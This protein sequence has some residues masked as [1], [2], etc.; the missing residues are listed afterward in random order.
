MNSSSSLSSNMTLPSTAYTTTPGWAPIS[1]REVASKSSELNR[2][3]T[4]VLELWR[5]TV[6][7]SSYALGAIK[8][9][10]GSMHPSDDPSC[11][12][13]DDVVASLELDE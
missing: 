4:L 12:A 5:V 9:R 10:V 11:I 13:D 1:V 3:M 7:N 2:H 6:G 8:D